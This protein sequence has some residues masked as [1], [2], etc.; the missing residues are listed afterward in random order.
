L[1]DPVAGPAL[2]QHTEEVLA[3]LLHLSAAQIDDLCAQGI[4]AR[5]SAHGSA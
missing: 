2:G 5:E 1:A 3:G 4:V